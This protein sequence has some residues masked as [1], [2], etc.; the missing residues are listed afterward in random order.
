[1][2]ETKTDNKELQQTVESIAKK[3]HGAP[4][5]NGGFD[6][7][8]VIVEHI[9]EKQD[10][11][12]EKIN[13]IHDDLYE[14]DD[15]LYARVKMVETV[16]ADFAKKQAEHLATDEKTLVSL[17]ESLKK[18]S[19]KDDDLGKKAETTLRLKKIAGEDLEKLESMIRVKSVWLNVW[20]KA[21]WL[22]GGGILAAIGKTVWE[23]ISRK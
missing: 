12:T 21:V 2:S 6:R 4:A 3:I 9:R 15:G 16:A 17:N 18:L 10:D 5:L 14:P 23:L 8:L 11:T 1:M 7:M 22:L 19:E 13:K 20:S